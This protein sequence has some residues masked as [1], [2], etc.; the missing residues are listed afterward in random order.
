MIGTVRLA[1]VAEFIEGKYRGANVPFQFVSIDTRTLQPGDLYVAL[2]GDRLDGHEFIQQAMEKGA[3]GVLVS[4]KINLDILNN[5]DFNLVNIKKFPAVK[6]LK[7]LPKQDSLFETIL[8]SANDLLV[9]MFL[10]KEIKFVD[11]SIIL[12]KLLKLREFT[13]YKSKKSKNINDILKLHHYVSLKIKS[14]SV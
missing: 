11:I 3:C 7:K 5:L 10:K 6:I 2:V 1:E 9:S 13:K 12:S 4:K 8:V 14:M